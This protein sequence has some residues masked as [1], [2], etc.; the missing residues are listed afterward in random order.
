MKR[1]NWKKIFAVLSMCM[2]IFSCIGCSNV[3]DGSGEVNESEKKE[4][5]EKE[6]V[7]KEE[8]VEAVVSDRGF[9]KV[10]PL[11]LP[12]Y[13]TS[14]KEDEDYILMAKEGDGYGV[15]EYVSIEAE[16]PEDINPE[17]SFYKSYVLG[18][19]Y[20]LEMMRNDLEDE[21]TKYEDITIG[22]QSYIFNRNSGST[23]Y[24]TV[25]NN[26]PVHIHVKG[27]S[28]MDNEEVMKAIESIEYVY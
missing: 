24:Y 26:Y 6:E 7:E 1:N 16:K 12:D 11:D 10:M 17:A 27:E 21:F 15:G 18:E 8:V 28:L 4:E 19:E 9:I 14:A 20:T 22:E 13:I 3:K 25:V 2:I 5:V 23:L